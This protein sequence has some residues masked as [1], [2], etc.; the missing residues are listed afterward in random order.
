[1][2]HVIHHRYANSID[3]LSRAFWAAAVGLALLAVLMFYYSISSGGHTAL[4]VP[5]LLDPALI[6]PALPFVPIL[7]TSRAIGDDGAWNV[8]AHPRLSLQWTT[9]GDP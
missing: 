1:M 2:V 6:P 3:V 5:T 7:L 4:V 9:G 8:R